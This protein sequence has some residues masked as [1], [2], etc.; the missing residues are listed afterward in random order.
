MIIQ[1]YVSKVFKRFTTHSL[2]MISHLGIYP[3]E[4]RFCRRTR[5]GVNAEL[6]INRKKIKKPPRKLEPT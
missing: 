6:C 2:I 1:Y 4:M 5:R 3:Q